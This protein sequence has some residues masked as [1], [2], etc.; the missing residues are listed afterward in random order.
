M[1]LFS[2][3]R[4]RCEA[5]L[6]RYNCDNYAQ[7]LLASLVRNFRNCAVKRLTAILSSSCDESV[8]EISGNRR[9]GRS[10]RWSPKGNVSRRDSALKLAARVGS[11][12]RER[13]TTIPR[14][15]ECPL[16]RNARIT[17][18]SRRYAIYSPK[19]LIIILANPVF[20]S[21]RY[22]CLFNPRKI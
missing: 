4:S 1:P 13:E 8:N 14:Q 17:R 18:R 20:R 21:E 6:S 16:D 5:F 9:I 22:A 2:S 7:T 3:I 11:R 12:N 15:S 10:A 19:F